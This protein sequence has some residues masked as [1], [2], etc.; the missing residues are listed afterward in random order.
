MMILP[1]LTYSSE[2]LQKYISVLHCLTWAAIQI[3]STVGKVCFLNPKVEVK[4]TKG[5]NYLSYTY[6]I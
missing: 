1:A 3:P 2:R 6:G 5:T 4:G